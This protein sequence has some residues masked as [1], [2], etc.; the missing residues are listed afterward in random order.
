MVMITKSPLFQ[1][2]TRSTI[3]L[4]SFTIICVLL[5]TGVN[6]ITS[7]YIELAKLEKEKVIFKD[8]FKLNDVELAKINLTCRMVSSKTI[9]GSEHLL[10]LKSFMHNDNQFQLI[11]TIAPDGYN[12]SIR[13][14]IGIE[15]GKIIGIRILQHN[16]TPGLGDK[17]DLAKSNWVHQFDQLDLASVIRWNVKKHGG[18]FDAFTGATITPQA[19]IRAVKTVANNQSKISQLLLD[20]E[21]CS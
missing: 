6:W 17:I 15:K 13:I 11:Q 21:A 19:V 2:M 4:M 8:I 12:G 1:T 14:A 16:E 3:I 18:Q 9:L 5:L 10:P 20:A 7:P